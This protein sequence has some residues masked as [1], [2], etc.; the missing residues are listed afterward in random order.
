MEITRNGILFAEKLM[1][2]VA[3]ILD[4]MLDEGS[5]S[6]FLQSLLEEFRQKR[7]RQV[8]VM[9]LQLLQ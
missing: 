2:E 1:S 8:D 6:F 7:Y 4:Q 5:R 3:F 9:I